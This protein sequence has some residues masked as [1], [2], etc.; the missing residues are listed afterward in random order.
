[1]PTPED[2]VQFADELPDDDAE[3]GNEGGF[4]D[5]S[6]TGLDYAAEAATDDDMYDPDLSGSGVEE[7]ADDAGDGASYGFESAG[8]TARFNKNCP[9]ELPIWV[10]NL[11]LTSQTHDLMKF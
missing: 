10:L 7:F 11:E 6:D 2:D 3:A 1:M 5:P 4:A 9:H 8:S